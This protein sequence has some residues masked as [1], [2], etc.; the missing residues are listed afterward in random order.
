MTDPCEI[1]A[2]VHKTQLDNIS[3][4]L[5]KI[6]KTQQENAN[7]INDLKRQVDNGGV[8]IKVFFIFAAVVTFILSLVKLAAVL[9]G[10]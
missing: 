1:T 7:S 4:Q 9:K 3:E 6:E 10:I 2:A 5:K 8:A